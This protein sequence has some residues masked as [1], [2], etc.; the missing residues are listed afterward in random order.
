MFNANIQAFNLAKRGLQLQLG[1]LSLQHATFS[2]INTSLCG[3][4]PLDRT[5]VGSSRVAPFD[6]A[7]LELRTWYCLP[8]QT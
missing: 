3:S 1:P 5:E 2:D 7:H 4:T 8:S 6:K